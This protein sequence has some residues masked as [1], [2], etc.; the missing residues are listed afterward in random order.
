M[1]PKETSIREQAG[2]RFE[3]RK[4]SPVGLAPVARGR[5]IVQTK[6]G[7]GNRAGATMTGL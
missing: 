2:C 3:T 5:P 7:P 4:T 1:Y 6:A